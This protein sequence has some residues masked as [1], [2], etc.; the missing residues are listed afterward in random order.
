MMTP[1]ELSQRIKEGI[2]P[3]V[4]TPFTEDGRLDEDGLR[5]QLQWLFAQ[6]KHGDL[7]GFLYGGTNAEFYAL[8][9]KEYQTALRIIM[10]EAARRVPVIAGAMA[11][12]TKN[13][14]E[15]AK[16][17]QDLGVDAIQIVNPYYITPSQDGA[18]RHF[19][20]VARA[21]DVGLELYNNPLTTHIYVTADTVARLL[22]ATGDK[23]VCIKEYSP[24]NFDFLEMVA[25]VGNKIHILDNNGPFFAHQVY[26]ASLG[27]RSFMVQPQFAPLAYDFMHAIWQ[28]N[29]ARLEELSWQT[30]PLHRF[31]Q[32]LERTQPNSHIA[33]IKVEMEC[34]GLP[35]GKPRLPLLP[36]SDEARIKAELARLLARAGLQ[37]ASAVAAD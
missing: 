29:T 20:A 18:L 2:I 21:V 3:I 32:E 22:D 15:L 13:T 36:L 35:A 26:A 11:I 37:L 33:R 30:L 19:E 5:A 16:R 12:G 7:V 28:E 4:M 17:I 24:T 6:D 10:D 23:Y 27:C 14:I 9:D 25:R 31:Y 34:L 8:S 1:S